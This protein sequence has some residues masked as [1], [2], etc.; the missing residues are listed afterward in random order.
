MFP[1]VMGKKEL[2]ASDFTLTGCCS[3][4]Q[5]PFCVPVI[6]LKQQEELWAL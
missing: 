1:A 2:T 6:F 5:W 3:W 4:K